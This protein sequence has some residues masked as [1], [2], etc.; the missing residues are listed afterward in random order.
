MGVSLFSHVADNMTRGNGVKLW[1]GRFRL[2]VRKYFSKRVVRHWNELPRVLV[3]S[4]SM[5]MLKKN[6]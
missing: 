2:D 5:K 1:Q 3:E 4:L 6:V